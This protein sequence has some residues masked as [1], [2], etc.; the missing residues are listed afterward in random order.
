MRLE[1]EGLKRLAIVATNNYA[2]LDAGGRVKRKGDKLKGSLS[3]FASCNNLVVNDAVAEALLHDVPPE[4]TVRACCDPVR[5]C[6]ITRRTGKV[7]AAVLIDDE[8]GHET[9]LPKVSRWYKAKDS[10]RHIVHRFGDGH[11][12]TPPGAVGIAMAL[13]LADGRLPD[14]LD[15]SWYI[16]EARRVIQKARGYRHRA[17]RRLE[18]HPLAT[19]AKDAGLCPCPKW[20]GKAVLPGSDAAAPTWL[21]DWSGIETVGTYTGPK[22][23]ILVLDIDEHARFATWVEAG[24]S[25]LLGDRWRDL[26]G[27][28]V[29]VRGDV[30]AEDVRTGRARGKLIFRLSDE[31]AGPIAK[32]SI[33]RWK[34]DRGVEV[35]FGKGIPSVLGRHPSGEPY[36]IEGTIS[37]APSWLVEGLAPQRTSTRTTRKVSRN[38]KAHPHDPLLAFSPGTGPDDLDRL[39]GELAELSPELMVDHWRRKDHDGRIILVA[40]CPFDHDSGRKGDADLDAGFHEDGPYIHCLHA[41]CTRIHEIN[42]RLR[43]KL[44]RPETP[45]SEPDVEVF[46]LDKPDPEDRPDIIVTTEESKVNDQAIEAISVDRRIFQRNFKLVSIVRD[47]KPQSDPA[48]RVRRPE[49]TPVIMEI[50]GDRLR[51]VLTD[52]ANWQQFK[53]DAEGKFKLVP[54]HPPTW[55]IRAVLARKHWPKI[56]YLLGVIE[57]PT[58]RPDGSVIESAGYD[59]TTGLLYVPGMTFP[60]LPARPSREDARTAADSL[61]EIVRDFP[62]KKDPDGGSDH[63]A[64]WLAALLT[65]L[66]RFLIDGPCP[67]FLLESN[68]SGAGKSKLCDLVAVIV[69]GREMTRTGYYHDAVEMDKQITATALAGDRIVL[70][71]NLDNG[72]RLGNSSLDRALTG[73]T[74]RGRVL[75]KLE[76]TP[77]LDL[78]TV[79]YCTG[80]NPSLCGDV[81]RRIIPCRLESPMERPEERDDFTIKSCQC[82]CYGDLIAHV[83][84]ARGRLVVSTLTILRAYILAGKPA[85]ALK[86]IDFPA[87]SGL[88]RNAVFWATGIDPAAGRKDLSDSDPDRQSCA[89][90]AA[91]WLEVQTALRVKGMTCADLLNT[92]RREENADK[93]TTIRESFSDLWPK[94][95]PGELPSSGSIGMKIKAIRGKSFS[96]RHFR[97]LSSEERRKIWSVVTTQRDESEGSKESFSCPK[98]SRGMSDKCPGSR[99]GAH[100]RGVSEDRKETPQTP[101]THTDEDPDWIPF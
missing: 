42:D 39:K 36:R 34:K 18:G 65:P 63:K 59:Q 77:D 64:A 90:L 11:H 89:T 17:M 81:V 70:F 76:M 74:Y 52:V 94:L 88:I 95:K 97:E 21:W 5:F 96:G 25:P 62:F 24:N 91:G 41:S 15:R 93:F 48:G 27:C 38:G 49:G 19:Q 9:E 86:P 98:K 60:K 83:K 13:D 53:P 46:S 32:L 78:I 101:Q 10:R 92:L 7:T 43:G 28:L 40:P 54:A 3:P 30:A 99:V 2:T 14:D 22:V 85:Q 68:V 57:C 45:E 20:G 44:P 84:R 61:F 12:T 33:G 1:V 72:G 6:R 82:G 50:E 35:F 58:L 16:A 100:A 8:T 55:S 23:G 31:A 75:G 80:N 51:E 29:S 4:R 26:A 56:R 87:W 71:D 37:D 67:L 79:F 69:T 66:G 73:R 47:A